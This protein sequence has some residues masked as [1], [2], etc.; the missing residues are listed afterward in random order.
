MAANEV[1]YSVETQII[2]NGKTIKGTLSLYRDGYE[3]NGERMSVNW[4]KVNCIKGE[5]KAFIGL[6]KK[7]YVTFC[8]GKNDSP[9]F[10]LKEK[11]AD[12]LVHK[13]GELAAL[14]RERRIAQE[15]LKRQAAEAEAKRKA[16]EAEAEAKRK[17]AEAVG[18]DTSCAAEAKKKVTDKCKKGTTLTF[19]HYPQT[20]SGN[21]STEIEWLVLARKGQMALNISRYALNWKPYNTKATY[22]TWEKCTL[23]TWLNGDFLNKAF[24]TAEQGAIVKS[25]VKAEKTPGYRTC[26]ETS[27]G[28][29]T[30]DQVFLLSI[31]EANKYFTTDEARSP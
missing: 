1:F 29:D 12:E 25:T 11:Y 16:A 9:A 23:R 13:V 7:F 4:E 2:E 28:N 21:D 31:K 26:P 6:F 14:I 8:E 10:V 5:T 30:Q 19:G 3:F 18:S 15:T 20:K 17:A 22:I 24:T 27:P